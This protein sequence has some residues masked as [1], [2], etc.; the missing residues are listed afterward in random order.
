MSNLL[1]SETT[2]KRFTAAD[3]VQYV[4]AAA[5][6]ARLKLDDVRRIMFARTAL[7]TS[8]DEAFIIHG[9][10]LASDQPQC[11]ITAKRRKPDSE[12]LRTA[13]ATY[14]PEWRKRLGVAR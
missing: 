10:P 9:H 11:V 5:P 14:R 2:P 7:R 8:V 4:S 3:L 13:L 1:D 6:T 12:P